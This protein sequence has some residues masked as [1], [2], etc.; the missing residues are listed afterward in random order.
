MRPI[1]QRISS[2]I[3]GSFLPEDDVEDGARGE[4]H[5]AYEGRAPVPCRAFVL[6][7]WRERI[8]QPRELLVG[9]GAPGRKRDP[10][11]QADADRERGERQPEVL[12]HLARE[13]MDDEELT[14]LV[15][16]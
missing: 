2:P 8:D 7:L 12:R 14:G 10:E 16:S 1:G 3:I 15:Y 13:G 9:L 11:G 6:D 4:Q 5:R